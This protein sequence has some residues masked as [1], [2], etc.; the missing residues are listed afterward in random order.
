MVAVLWV[1]TKPVLALKEIPQPDLA[2]AVT[3]DAT[4]AVSPNLTPDAE[5]RA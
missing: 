4:P 2:P 1:L 3:P 5:P